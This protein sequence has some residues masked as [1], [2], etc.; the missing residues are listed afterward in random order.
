MWLDALCKCAAGARLN[1]GWSA[2]FNGAALDAKSLAAVNKRVAALF[3]TCTP[4]EWAVVLNNAVAEQGMQVAIATKDT[5][6]AEAAKLA[7]PQGAMAAG[8][9]PA[10]APA[11]PS[12]QWEWCDGDIVRLTSPNRAFH[13][14]LAQIESC[15]IAYM[16]VRL[17]EGPNMNF[18][19]RVQPKSAALHFP[20]ILEPGWAKLVAAPQ[21]VEASLE[22]LVAAPA[23]VDTKAMSMALYGNA[24]LEEDD[25]LELE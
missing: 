2:G 13:G 22:E 4:P 25:V 1:A 19:H 16:N 24:K 10:A 15:T 6:A 21:E 8:S 3:A 14:Y 17:Q 11:G 7:H 23:P 9:T 12:S 5:A 20:S 18:V